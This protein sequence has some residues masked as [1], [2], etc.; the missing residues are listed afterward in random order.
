MANVFAGRDGLGAYI[1]DPASFPP[2][3][4]ISYDEQWVVIND[5]FPKSSV[6]LLLLPRDATKA[7]LHPFSALSDPEFLAAVKSEVQKLRALVASE[8]RRKYALY[9][10]TERLRNEAM[11]AEPP[12]SADELP[13]GRDWSKEVVAGVHA[14]PSMNHLHIHVLSVDRY[15]PCMKHR[16]HYNSF[17]TPFFVPVEDFPLAAED[18]RRHPGREGYLDSDL[19]CWRCGENFGNRFARLKGHLEHEFEKWRSI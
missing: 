18:K 15:S 4:V 6:H 10:Q 5:M 17:N 14:H 2:A 16:K 13:Q 8:L 1:A 7:C 3:R 9:S 12:L 19:K 11:D